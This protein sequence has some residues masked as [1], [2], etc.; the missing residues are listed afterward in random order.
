MED[1]AA[2]GMPVGVSDG[3]LVG[4]AVEVALGSLVASGVGVSVGAGVAVGGREVKVE[5][6]GSGD[7]VNVS[8]GSPTVAV[9]SEACDWMSSLSAEV[10]LVNNAS[11]NRIKTSLEIQFFIAIASLS[12]KCAFLASQDCT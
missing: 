11:I 3:R 9:A 8:V 12:K 4:I 7:G 5:V 2:V 10:Q 6:G 1:W